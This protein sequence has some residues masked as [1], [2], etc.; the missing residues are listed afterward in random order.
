MQKAL[1][2]SEARPKLGR[3]LDE[4][5]KGKSVYLR[6]GK[7]LLRIEPVKPKLQPIPRRPVGFFKFNDDL[8]AL[9][10]RAEPSFTPLDES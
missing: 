8:T 2:V 4:A 7:R 5:I 10:D 6:R 9:A 1:T 3:L